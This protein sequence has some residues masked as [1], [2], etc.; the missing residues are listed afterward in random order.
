MI[1]NFTKIDKTNNHLSP[2]TIKTT[3][4][5]VGN[6]G[7]GLGHTQNDNGLSRFKWFHPSDKWIS[8]ENKDIKQQ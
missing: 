5:G 1:N 8:N 7:P 3:T 2:Q 4:N 6:Y